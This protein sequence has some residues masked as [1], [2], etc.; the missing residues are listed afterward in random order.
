MARFDREAAAVAAERVRQSIFSK[1]AA[2]HDAGGATTN[3]LLSQ[4]P[5]ELQRAIFERLDAP[6][7]LALAQTSCTLYAT[8]TSL[9][10]LYAALLSRLHYEPASGQVDELRRQ[11]AGALLARAATNAGR[12][13]W[14]RTE[15]VSRALDPQVRTDSAQVQCFVTARAFP[16]PTEGLLRFVPAEELSGVVAEALTTVTFG[17]DYNKLLADPAFPATP[18]A[19]Q[20]EDDAWH[21]SYFTTPPPL[22]LRLQL[23]ADHQAYATLAQSV[24]SIVEKQIDFTVIKAHPCKPPP[25]GRTLNALADLVDEHHQL[26]MW[27]D[28][29]YVS[30]GHTGHRL[31][32]M[33]RRLACVVQLDYYSNF[34]GGPFEMCDCGR[35]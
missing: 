1:G 3:G 11:L 9:P 5:A 4:L 32:V 14:Q 23:I 19:Y 17:P 29:S 35:G 16:L 25:V 22:H 31:L 6:A 10:T 13:P 8:I 24:D 18:S 28:G 2:E 26:L 27:K 15:A 7:L 30:D 34:C 20:P 21:H 33:G 12:L